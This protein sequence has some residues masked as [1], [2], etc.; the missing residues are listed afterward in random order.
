MQRL[1]LQPTE[2]AQWDALLSEAQFHAEVSLD[3]D[4]KAY[5]THA[6]IRFSKQ[7][8]L[9]DGIIAREM[10]EAL[11]Q[12]GRRYQLQALREVGD[13][14]LIF[15]G[16]FPGRAARRKVNLRYYIDMG[17]SAYH[18]VASLE[19]TSFAEIAVALRDNFQLL[20]T[21]LSSIR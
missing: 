16:L 14:C 13:R 19:Q 3:T 15:S 4:V 10:L 18:R 7:I 8:N 9:A 6:L 5:L 21:L 1:F 12:A 11:G 2:L 20:V 17:Q